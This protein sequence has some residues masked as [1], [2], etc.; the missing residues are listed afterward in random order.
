MICSLSIALLS[1]LKL[2]IRTA[3]VQGLWLNGIP[4]FQLHPDFSLDKRGGGLLS[5]GR[6]SLSH[7]S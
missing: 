2:R 4:N 7:L 5:F 1:P 6:G 3:A